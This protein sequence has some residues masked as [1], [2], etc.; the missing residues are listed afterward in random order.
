[1]CT[2]NRFVY[3]ITFSRLDF[4]VN[5]AA[6]IIFPNVNHWRF[7]CLFDVAFSHI[8]MVSVDIT[9]LTWKK[10]FK[11]I[12]VNT[13]AIWCIPVILCTAATPGWGWERC[14]AENRIW[15]NPIGIETGPSLELSDRE[16]FRAIQGEV[17]VLILDVPIWVCSIHFNFSLSS[18]QGEV[19]Q[20]MKASPKLSTRLS[21]AV[22]S[23]C[24]LGRHKNWQE[25]NN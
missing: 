2:R 10:Y 6:L 15:G 24:V 20:I 5:V 13:I 11:S 19:S 7:V 16:K 22:E 1:M 14:K 23:T 9:P 21:H 4:F 25:L 8:T 3:E 12:S 18:V 17:L